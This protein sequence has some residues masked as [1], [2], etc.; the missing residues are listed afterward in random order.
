MLMLM[1]DP[2]DHPSGLSL[3]TPGFRLPASGEHLCLESQTV[4]SKERHSFP[5]SSFLGL[6]MR[7]TTKYC[8]CLSHLQSSPEVGDHNPELWQMRRAQ[9]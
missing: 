7:G 8:F 6:R 1:I 9:R 2:P 4:Q 5:G 3:S